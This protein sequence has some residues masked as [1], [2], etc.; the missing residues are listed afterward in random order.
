MLEYQYFNTALKNTVDTLRE[1]ILRNNRTEYSPVTGTY[2]FQNMTLY[3]NILHSIELT[4]AD[5]ILKSLHAEVDIASRAM[6]VNIVIL[7]IAVLLSPVIV[8]LVH[9]M[10]TNIQKFASSYKETLSRYA[11]EK[12]KAETLLHERIPIEIAD[13]V[14]SK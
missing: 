4:L 14:A 8:Y 6:S 11:A 10:T 9:K 1:E 12:R 7:L 3:I 5:D 2:W 13:R